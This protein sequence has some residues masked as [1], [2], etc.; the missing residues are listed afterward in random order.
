MEKARDHYLGFV[1]VMAADKGRYGKI[2]EEMENS[3]IQGVNKYPK[4]L[5][6]AHTLLTYCKNAPMNNKGVGNDSDGVAFTQSGERRRGRV[7]SNITCYTCGKKGHISTH[8]PNKGNEENGNV[9][10][11]VETNTSKS[12]SRNESTGFSNL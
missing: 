1:F 6:E 4:T 9:N 2:L 11:Q 7:L 8:C 10:A 3:Y 12:N 5:N